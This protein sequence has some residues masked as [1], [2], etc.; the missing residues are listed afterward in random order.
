MRNPKSSEGGPR[1]AICE[2][3]RRARL[4]FDPPLTQDELSGRLAV[5]QLLLDRVAITKIENG[6]RCVFD[7]ELKALAEVLKVDVR[8]LLGMQSS[9]GP[10][11]KSGRPSDGL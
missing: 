3:V 7:F 8:W 2:R 10:T 1:N 9:G 4:A 6:Q 5:K 11:K